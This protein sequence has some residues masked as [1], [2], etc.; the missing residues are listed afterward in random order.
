M[1]YSYPT[2][3]SLASLSYGNDS[4]LFHLCGLFS[5][6]IDTFFSLTA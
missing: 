1:D 6:L 2:E 3:I 4:T 5:L